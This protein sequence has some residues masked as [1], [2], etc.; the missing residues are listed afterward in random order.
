ME[1]VSPTLPTALSLRCAS[2]YMVLAMA[3]ASPTNA[4]VPSDV[5]DALQ[6]VAKDIPWLSRLAQC[7]NAPGLTDA[8]T[9]PYACM[10]PVSTTL[11]FSSDSLRV[12]SL[13]SDVDPGCGD[14]VADTMHQG[15]RRRPSRAAVA[16]IGGPKDDLGT[17]LTVLWR[18]MSILPAAG[19]VPA[20][21]AI[22]AAPLV[23]KDHLLYQPGA[24][25]GPPLTGHFLY[26]DA[27]EKRIYLYEPDGKRHPLARLPTLPEG[28]MASLWEVA[29]TPDAKSLIIRVAALQGTPCDPAAIEVLR[30]PIPLSPD[31]TPPANTSFGRLLRCRAGDDAAC[32]AR[33][34]ARATDCQ[35]SAEAI[36]DRGKPDE[37]ALERV[38]QLYNRGCK[39][40]DPL[41]CLGLAEAFDRFCRGPDSVNNPGCKA[42]ANAQGIRIA[43]HRLP[44]KGGIPSPAPTVT[45]AVQRLQ[46]QCRV[47]PPACLELAKI[48][49]TGRFNVR[50]NAR[51]SREYARK[52]LTGLRPR[53]DANT[54][55]CPLVTEA[56]ALLP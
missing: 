10:P 28:A 56:E 30:L 40:R 52:A 20:E 18:L 25:L 32:E 43:P 48:Y 12:A 49:K 21:P 51:R 36:L 35:G 46:R 22:L 45:T 42:I 37:A 23:A 6:P 53:C 14:H 55:V 13:E 27:A 44:T 8:E 5:I 2:A 38:G 29:I 7:L 3:A 41:A 24:L 15:P 39:G 1:R 9:T 50:P 16:H 34:D 17:R 31:R 33:C 54:A 26:L 19:F 4:R 47:D 11:G